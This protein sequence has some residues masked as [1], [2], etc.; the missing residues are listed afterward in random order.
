MCPITYSQFEPG[1]FGMSSRSSDPETSSPKDLSEQVK[2]RIQTEDQLEFEE[3]PSFDEPADEDQIRAF[4]DSLDNDMF[5]E[6]MN[7]LE[8]EGYVV[9]QP[10]DQECEVLQFPTDGSTAKGTSS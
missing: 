2:A 7:F 5:A 1:V 9:I 4:V 10:G 3:D 6:V 8:E